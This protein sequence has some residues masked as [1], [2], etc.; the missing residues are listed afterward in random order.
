MS[1]LRC[2]LLVTAAQCVSWGVSKV[3]PS[4][5][6]NRTNQHV[7][8]KKGDVTIAGIVPLHALTIPRLQ[9]FTYVVGDGICSLR[10]AAHCDWDVAGCILTPFRFPI[11]KFDILSQK[12]DMEF[13]SVQLY[14]GCN[15][16][17]KVAQWP[18]L[19]ISLLN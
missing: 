13:T 19:D 7:A 11:Y 6:L 17:L 1:W 2:L 4:C 10:D 8:D 14:F 12:I 16:E 15:I 9:H 18:C 5:V 3:A